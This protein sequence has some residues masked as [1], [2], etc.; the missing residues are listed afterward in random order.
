VQRYST[1]WAKSWIESDLEFAGQA[2]VPG[3]CAAAEH[4]PPPGFELTS[5]VVRT[6]D[7]EVA[8]VSPVFRTAYRLDTSLPASLRRPLAW[9]ERFNPRMV[10]LPVLGLGSPLM[11]RCPVGFRGCAP[12]SERVEVFS[13][14][15]DAI[16]SEARSTGAGLTAVKDLAELEYGWLDPVL[17]TRQYAKMASL[18]I[19]VLDLPFIS[20]DEYLGTLSASVR[21][22]LRRKMRRSIGLVRFT[23]CSNIAGV[24]NSIAELY[25]ETRSNGKGSYG[26]FD[27]LAPH[28]VQSILEGVNGGAKV[29]LGWVGDELASFAL[30]LVGTDSAYAHQIGMRYSFARAHN[31]YF[32]N[33]I[34][35]VRFCI[36]RGIRRLEFG[37]TSYPLKIR[38][39]CRLEP[40]W[41]YVRHCA[42]PINAALGL[43]APRFGFDR[44]ELA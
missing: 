35:A 29:L 39:G 28:Y 5:A 10:T 24:E 21:R 3:F 6:K 14:L 30:I 12:A 25:E 4:A 27:A 13:R 37:Q 9:L 32:L 34:A 41:I 26:N 2:S 38:L 15:L 22:D 33:W 17:R 11:D 44:V 23:E 16:E 20:I 8:A 40:S 18:P 19:A 43:L 31:L 7:G 42:R 1:S 36:A